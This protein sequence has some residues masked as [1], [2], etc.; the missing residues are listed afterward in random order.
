MEGNVL[1]E[2]DDAVQGCLA[3]QRDERSADWEQDEGNVDMENQGSCS[4]DHVCRSKYRSGASQC[5]LEV[6]VEESESEDHGVKEDE[7]G[8]KS[9]SVPFIDHPNVDPLFPSQWSR[10][11]IA[12]LS[13]HE[14]ACERWPS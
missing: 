11:E 14:H 2:L 9:S 1:V 13:R 12:H 6:V 7:Y 3:G 5:V 4:G 8:N 10:S